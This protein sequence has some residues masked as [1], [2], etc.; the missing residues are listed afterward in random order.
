[1]YVSWNIS[2]VTTWRE[3]GR[4]TTGKREARKR[5][6]NGEEKKENRKREG[7]K[8][9][10]EGGKVTKWGEDFFFFFPKPLIFVLGLPKW[11]F[12]T[13]KKYFTS[14]KKSWKITSPPLKKFLV[15]L[16][17]IYQSLLFSILFLTLILFSYLQLNKNKCFQNLKK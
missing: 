5:R 2:G 11:E 17:K 8:L 16:C 4:G 15:R 12:S 7:G 1:M 3:G 13:G 10:M 14:G 6:E 9:K